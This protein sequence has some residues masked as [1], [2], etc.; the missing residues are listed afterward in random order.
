MAW[1]VDPRLLV[2]RI[3]VQWAGTGA[4]LPRDAENCVRHQRAMP[5]KKPL[6]EKLTGRGSTAIDFSQ[7]RVIPIYFSGAQASQARRPMGGCP[8]PQIRD[9]S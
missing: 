6:K 7:R 3:F 8:A 5:Q 9:L 1:T 2:T 4:K